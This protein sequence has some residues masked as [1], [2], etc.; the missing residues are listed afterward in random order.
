MSRKLKAL[1]AAAL[2]LVVVGAVAGGAQGAD[3]FH[4]SVSPCRAT[5][6]TD[7][8]GTTAHQVLV[9]ENAAKTE[10]VSFTCESFRADAELSETTSEIRTTFTNEREAYDNCTVNGTPGVII[11]MNTCAYAFRGGAAAREDKGEIHVECTKA[12]DKIETTLPSGCV[13]TAG[14][15]TL[16]GVGYHN[17][18]EAGKTT[19]EATVTANIPGVAVTA[20]GTKATCGI[21]PAQTLTGTY[22]TANTI[23][24]GETPAGTMAN[25]WFE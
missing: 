6:K 8:T 20:D 10:S 21:N 4:C 3:E 16:S 22:T 14:P 1:V 19:T 13:M 18:G 24:T 2:A 7:G 25:I 11:H 17:I 12:G 5:T 9:I 15:Q 23:V